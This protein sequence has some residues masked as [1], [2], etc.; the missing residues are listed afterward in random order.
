MKVSGVS[1]WQGSWREGT[2]TIS[3][4]TDTVNNSSFSF[5][6]RFEGAPGSVPE[7]L[8]AAAIAGCFNQALANNLGMVDFVASNITTSVTIELG[9]GTNGLPTIFYVSAECK[10]EV[11]GISEIDFSHCAERAR[12]NCTIAKLL[13]MEIRLE[14]RLIQ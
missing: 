4:L 1:T 8:L 9:F 10:T 14:A 13:N 6:S 12:T 7:E 5:A 2:G 3:T 11:V